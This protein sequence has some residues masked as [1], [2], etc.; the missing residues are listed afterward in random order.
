MAAGMPVIASAE[1]ESATFVR[2]AD[3]GILVDPLRPEQIAD[4][5]VHLISD[6][7]RAEAMGKRGRGLILEKYNWESEASKLIGLHQQLRDA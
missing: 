5:I 6:P 3:A 7:A 4:A 1:G 2:E